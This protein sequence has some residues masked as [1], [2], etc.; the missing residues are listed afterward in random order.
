MSSSRNPSETAALDGGLDKPRR[1]IT[2]RAV[3]LAMLLTF[4]AALIGSYH[5]GSLGLTV[6][7]TGQNYVTPLVLAL[8]L[9]FVLAIN[10]LLHRI[11]RPLALRGGELALALALSLMAAPLPRF[12]VQ[13]QVST[14][15][16]TTAMLDGE[17]TAISYVH[18]KANLYGVLRDTEAEAASADGENENENVDKNEKVYRGLLP[19]ADSKEFHFG[20]LPDSRTGESW[21]SGRLRGPWRMDIPWGV[22]VKPLLYWA[23]LTGVFLVFCVSF[24]YLVYRQ[25]AHR[26][27]VRFPLAELAADMIRKRDDRPWPDVFYMGS[28]WIGLLLMVIIF[29]MAGIHAHLPK[30]VEVKTKA[31]FYALAKNFPFLNDSYEGY[32]LLRPWVFFTIVAVAYLLPA[33]ISFTAWFMWPIMVGCTYF[34]FTQTGSRWNNQDNTM[35]L[36]GAWWAMALLIMYTGRWYYWGVLKTALGLRADGIDAQSTRIARVFLLALILLVAMLVVYGLPL[37]MAVV[38]IAILSVWFLVMCRLVAEMGIPWTPLAQTGPL[39]LMLRALGATGLGA[40]VYSL[41]TIFKSMLIPTKGSVLLLAA[42]AVANAAHVEYRL[43]GRQSSLKVIAP[44]L[45]VVLIVSAGLIIYMGYNTEGPHN[46]MHYYRTANMHAQGIHGLLQKVGR[47]NSAAQIEASIRGLNADGT[48]VRGLFHTHWGSVKSD[49]GFWTRFSVG[50]VLVLVVGLLRLK[51]PRFPFHPLPLVVLGTWLMSRYW[52]SFLIGWAI[53]SLILRIG[54]SR[55]F[56]RCRPFFTGMIAGQA[57]V[58]LGWVIVNIVCFMGNDFRFEREWW[59]FFKDIF[60]G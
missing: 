7:V 23:P 22:W 50:F 48:P 26:E 43:T 32:S 10:A 27:L 31:A 59:L 53:K 37:D 21:E 54:G 60:S 39:S 13:E 11:Y 41:V 3:L 6:S 36:S 57:L 19:L 25:W 9:V 34:Y 4:L 18:Q 15:G 47:A 56:E 51:M 16:R 5:D 2:I 24:G 12:L 35:L 52:W 28:F 55:L 46:D 44:F 1:V 33:E 30:M 38:W 58:L 20:V 17:E 29:S 45:I 49:E 14:I 8:L 40:K 42:P